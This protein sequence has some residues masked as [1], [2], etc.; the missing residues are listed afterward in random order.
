[1]SRPVRL[2]RQRPQQRPACGGARGAWSAANTGSDGLAQL[3]ASETGAFSAVAATSNASL[4]I[5]KTHSGDFAQ[6]QTGAT[7]TLTVSNAPQV[8][9]ESTRRPSP[10][11]FPAPH[12]PA[13]PPS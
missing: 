13:I 3:T 2:R 11:A 10:A 12:L 6:G 4:S 7:Y 1:M 9:C 8:L 5:S